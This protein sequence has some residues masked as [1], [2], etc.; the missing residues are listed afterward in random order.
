MENVSGSL[1]QIEGL[2]LSHSSVLPVFCCFLLSYVL[3]MLV[4]LG[5]C[6]VILR[7]RS[8][9][10]PMYLLLCNLCLNDIIGGTHIIPRLLFDLLRAPEKLLISYSAC[11]TQAFVT[12]MFATASHTILMI[13]AFDRYVAICNPL[14]YSTIMS[15][16][17]IVKLIASAWGVA[18]VMVGILIGLSLR[19]SRCRSLVT[20]PY[21]D[22]AS[23]FKLSCESTLI[24]NVYGL[25]YTALLLSASIGSILLTYVKITLVCLRGHSS[26]LNRR[27]LQTCST[28]LLVYLLLLLSGI[29]V[30]TLH[31]FPQYT[32]QRK[33]AAI[34]LF[35]GPGM[36]NPIIYGIQCRDIRRAWAQLWTPL[37]RGNKI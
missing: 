1:L 30:I 18:F 2:S 29:M 36:V 37:S 27:A 8:L 24:N 7:D 20:N 22:N 25:L 3:M 32:E 13:M 31:R 10:Q 6:V 16:R 26:S 23:L 34:V 28:H 14:H 11:A 17:M 4:N 15:G 33:L 21:C 12:H 19:L 9:H 35:T 5:N